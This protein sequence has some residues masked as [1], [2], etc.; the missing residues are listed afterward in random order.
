MKVYRS[1]VIPAPIDDV[2]ARVRAFDSVAAWNPAVATASMESGNATTVGAIRR[3]EIVDGS[4]FRETLLA[5]SDLERFYSYDILESPLP[6]TNYRSTHSFLEITAGNQTLSIWQGRF[7]CAPDAAGELARLVG[8]D[9]YLNGLEGL[10]LHL[11][12]TSGAS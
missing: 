1:M 5:H 8:D 7:D 4:R 3:L 6:V 12:Q 2:W 10:R 9:I 11:A